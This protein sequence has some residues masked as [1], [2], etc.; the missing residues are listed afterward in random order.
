MKKTYSFSKK[1][2]AKRGPFKDLVKQKPILS[3]KLTALLK[4]KLDNELIPFYRSQELTISDIMLAS[5]LWGMYMVPEFQFSPE[6]HSYLQKVSEAC[7][8]NYHEDYWK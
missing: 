3:S 2:E 6:I 5:H 7:K 8:F 1:K 4:Q